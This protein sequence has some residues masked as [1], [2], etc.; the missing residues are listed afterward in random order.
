MSATILLK[1]Y[2]VSAT[3]HKGELISYIVNNKELI[4]DKEAPG[5]NASDIEMFP[6]L[7]PQN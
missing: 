5:W 1:T 3:I 4:H 6:V 2:K 7:V